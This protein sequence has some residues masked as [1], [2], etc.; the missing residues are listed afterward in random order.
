MLLSLSQDT[1][2]NHV[3]WTTF[4]RAGQSLSQNIIVTDVNVA[5]L[6]SIDIKEPA[7]I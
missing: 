1:S 5:N 6:N 7:Y 3:A 4:V 2:R